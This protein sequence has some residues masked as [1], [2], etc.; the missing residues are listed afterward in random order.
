MMEI[1]RDFGN[2]IGTTGILIVIA[3]SKPVLFG[4]F[5]LVLICLGAI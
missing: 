5:L 2:R 1:R 4:F 3:R